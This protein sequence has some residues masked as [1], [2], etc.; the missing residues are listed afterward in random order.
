MGARAAFGAGIMRRECILRLDKESRDC[1]LRSIAHNT[2][3]LQFYYAVVDGWA[4]ISPPECL[5]CF[6]WV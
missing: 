3:T 6:T 1:I 4:L 2:D 5:E